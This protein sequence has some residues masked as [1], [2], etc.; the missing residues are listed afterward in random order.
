LGIGFI[1]IYS[2]KAEYPNALFF[3]FPG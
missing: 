2:Q 1:L 3:N